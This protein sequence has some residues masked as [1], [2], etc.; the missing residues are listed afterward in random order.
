MTA[1]GKMTSLPSFLMAPARSSLPNVEPPH[2]PQPETR[3]IS[4]RTGLILGLCLGLGYGLTH[5][6]LRLSPGIPWSGF[7][8]FGVKPFPGTSLDTLR[9]RYDAKG[10]SVRVD[11]DRLEKE[12]KER[13]QQRRDDEEI[14]RRRA[15]MEARERRLEESRRLE[16]EQ[17]P[18]EEETPL[19]T[20][21]EAALPIEPS[22]PR[23][24]GAATGLPEPAP[25]ET[26]APRPPV[27]IPAPPPPPQP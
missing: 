12:R 22:Q 20:Q 23:S 17:S 13:E 25:L 24:Q 10:Q 26:D 19:P 11:L 2:R 3:R 1:G 15:E 7:Q 4:W 27:D 21:P 8:P 5:R 6:L 18:Q 9:E 14:G 16:E